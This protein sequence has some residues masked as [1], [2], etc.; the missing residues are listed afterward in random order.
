MKATIKEQ[1]KDKFDYDVS[2]LTPYIDEQN[3]EILTALVES[4]NFLANFNLMTGVKGSEKIKMLE[5]T[6]V[7]QDA[8]TCGFTPS[9]G[10]AFFDKTISVKPLKINESYC[11]KVLNTVWTQMKNKVGANIEELDSPFADVI[12]TYKTKQLMAAIQDAVFLG[13]TTSIVPNLAHFDGLVKKLTADTDVPTVSAEANNFLTLRKM[14][15]A[16]SAD[17]YDSGITTPI[18]GSRA[19]GQ[20]VID[21]VWDNKDVNMNLEWEMNGGYETFIVPGTTIRF[22][23]LPQ[24]KN[25]TTLFAIP[26]EYVSVAVDGDKDEEGMEIKY[27]DTEDEL[28]LKV[29]FKLGAE[30]VFPDKFLKLA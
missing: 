11:N 25:E 3:P 24:I 30:Y 4:A 14:A 7:L 27:N 2:A 9:G 19:F 20:S 28:R 8:E 1:L 18:I 6:V 23:A 13:D 17:L 16:I 29:E 15:R 10:L 26:L 22:T 12:I 5:S 21:Y